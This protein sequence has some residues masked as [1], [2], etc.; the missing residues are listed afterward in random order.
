MAD[1]FFFSEYPIW[2]RGCNSLL[3]DDSL[4]GKIPEKINRYLWLVL[5][6]YHL[7]IFKC[8][9]KLLVD[10]SKRVSRAGGPAGVAHFDIYNCK[11]L[12]NYYGCILSRQY[13]L[14]I[15]FNMI[16]ICVCDILYN[17]CSIE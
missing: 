2:G 12:E 17:Q 8:C 13:S 9:N 5:S 3:L 15:C 6:V 10:M 11:N 14:S 7:K 4:H 16:Y 1:R